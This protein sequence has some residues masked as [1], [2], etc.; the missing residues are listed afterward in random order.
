MKSKSAVNFHAIQEWEGYVVEINDTHFTVRLTDLTARATIPGEEAE[1][2]FNQISEPDSSKMQVGSILH[3]VIGYERL[4][5]GK[6]K[7][8]SRIALKNVGVISKA[9]MQAGR[10]W[11]RRINAAFAP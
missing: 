11:A 9:D 3:W 4:P 8:V 6:R 1:I 10:E 5:G 7:E 2:P